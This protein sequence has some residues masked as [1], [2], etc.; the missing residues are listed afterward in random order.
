MSSEP[1][2]GLVDSGGDGTAIPQRVID[3]LRL[4]P[5]R[6]RPVAGYKGKP[7]K[8]LTFLVDIS[9]D[10]FKFELIEVVSCG[11]EEEI[12]IGRNLLNDLKVLLDGKNLNF[13]II[14]P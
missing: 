4:I 6:E 14:D 11:D 3:N 13:E 2:K 1:L 10:G 5:V 8:E 7:S 9:L 12:L